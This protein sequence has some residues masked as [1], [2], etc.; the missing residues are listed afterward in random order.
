MKKFGTLLLGGM[1]VFAMTVPVF[2]QIDNPQN[3]GTVALAGDPSTITP[4]T[5]V[6][7][8][9]GNG[10][11]DYGT[12]LTITLKKSAYSNLDHNTKTHRS[13]CE[14]D[15]NYSNSGWVKARSTS[16]SS[17]TGPR[18]STAYCNWDVQ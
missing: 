4:Y 11:W 3:G 12:G 13:S 10:R 15:G 16:K 5:V 8:D 2:A 7:V 9:N 6:S 14:I 17:T 1:L 18:N